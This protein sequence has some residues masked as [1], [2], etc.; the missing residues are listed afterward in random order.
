MTSRDPINAVRQYGRLSWRQ[1]GFLLKKYRYWYQ[2]FS[3]QSIGIVIGNTF[4]KY[5]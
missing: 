2:Q 3:A 5:R 4:R 1:L